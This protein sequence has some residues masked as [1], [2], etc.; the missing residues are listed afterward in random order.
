MKSPP[1]HPPVPLSLPLGLSGSKVS[2]P[3]AEEIRPESMSVRGLR[4]LVSPPP[5]LLV[6][7][8][9]WGTRLAPALGLGL[10][11]QR[12]IFTAG[13]MWGGEEGRP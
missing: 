2:G 13:A 10:W 7:L 4:E 1:R 11:G 8:L 9:G 3:G 5:A 6:P 12:D